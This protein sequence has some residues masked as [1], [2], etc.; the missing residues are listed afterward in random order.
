MHRSSMLDSLWT[1]THTQRTLSR[2]SPRPYQSLRELTKFAIT[3]QFNDSPNLSLNLLLDLA[4]PKT[5]LHKSS[6]VSQE[7]IAEEK[8]SVG[9]LASLE[10]SSRCLVK[11]VGRFPI[12]AQ[13]SS[14][15]RRRPTEEDPWSRS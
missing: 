9:Q 5:V 13:W 12:P 2:I 14:D 1:V 15:T 4:V 8:V 10:D 11:K 6:A 7:S 3:W